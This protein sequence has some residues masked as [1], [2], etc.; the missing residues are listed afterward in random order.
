[1]PSTWCRDLW[2]H[3]PLRAR[4][5]NLPGGYSLLC[6]FPPFTPNSVQRPNEITEWRAGLS[7]SPSRLFCRLSALAGCRD[8][9]LVLFLPISRTVRRYT[10]TCNTS[11]VASFAMHPEKV[12]SRLSCLR[13]VP[14][15]PSMIKRPAISEPFLHCSKMRSKS[16][17]PKRSRRPCGFWPM[18]CVSSISAVELIGEVSCGLGFSS[19]QLCR[20]VVLFGGWRC[21]RPL[22]A[23]SCARW[24][25]SHSGCDRQQ[26]A[27][28]RDWRS[29]RGEARRIS[30]GN[31]RFSTSGRA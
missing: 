1:M 10:S 21:G 27:R 20:D 6:V 25:R 8:S 26:S 5:Y 22:L 18:A 2:Q 9:P 4:S 3:W 30:C 29:I 11:S 14:Y 13:N 7:K 15:G 24:L 17:T 23:L 31:S 28:D 19:A 16:W 12:C